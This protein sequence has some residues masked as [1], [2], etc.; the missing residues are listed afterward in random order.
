M[1]ERTTWYGY[2]PRVAQTLE[3]V[4][5]TSRSLVESGTRLGAALSFALSLALSDGILTEL[6]APAL[7]SAAVAVL[8]AAA[9]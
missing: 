1:H 4:D 7:A 6:D 5:A 9:R 2:V 3:T 8:T